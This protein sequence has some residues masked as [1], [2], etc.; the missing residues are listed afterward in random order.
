MLV[1]ATLVKD[2]VSHRV[3][4]RKERIDYYAREYPLGKPNNIIDSL[5]DSDI[6]DDLWICDLC[7]DDMNIS[8]CILIVENMALCPECIQKSIYRY[9]DWRD[10]KINVCSLQCCTQEEEE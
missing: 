1:N 2:P 6:P 7:N 3:N 10:I 9:N 8:F 4:D 5:I